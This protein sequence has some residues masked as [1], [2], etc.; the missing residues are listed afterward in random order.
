MTGFQ[1][2]DV[3][4]VQGDFGVHEEREGHLWDVIRKKE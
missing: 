4:Q 2:H 3:L 1:D